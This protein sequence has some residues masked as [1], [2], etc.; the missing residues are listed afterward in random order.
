MNGKLK[1]WIAAI[2]LIL[3]LVLAWFMA[4]WL[5]LQGSSLWILRGALAFI[6]LLAFAL[7]LWWFIVKDKQGGDV[8]PRGRAAT[9][10]MR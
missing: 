3:W 1:Y 5:H 2:V 4:S 10:S 9:R 7:V 6:G 8:D